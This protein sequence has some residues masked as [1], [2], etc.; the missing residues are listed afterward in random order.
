MSLASVKSQIQ[1]LRVRCRHFG[2]LLPLP[3]LLLASS[4]VAKDISTDLN[5]VPISSD[6]EA[7]DSPWG[8]ASGGEWLS[9][10]PQFNPMLGRAGVKWLRA[11]QEWKTIQPTHGYW[12][13]AAAD[14]LVQ[15]ARANDLRLSWVLAYLAPWAS[16]DGGTRKFPIKD[17]QY[18]RDYVVQLVGR[19]HRDIKYWEVWNEFN[20]SF[21][22]SGTPKIYAELVREA[23]ISAKA[24]DPSAK[25][26][27][28]V[29]N[30]DVHFLDAVIK[31]GAAGHFDYVCVHPYEKLGALENDGEIDFLAMTAALRQMLA[32]NN[33][34]VDMPLW[35]TEMGEQTSV[36]P[37]QQADGKQAVMLAKAYLLSLAAGF[38]KIFWFEARGPSYG[39]NT[40]H[41]IIRSD[42]SVRPSYRALKTLSTILGAAPVG[43][44]W[45][46]MG[47]G[48]FGFLFQ[49][50][51]RATLAAWAPSKG[52]IRLTFPGDVRVVDLEGNQTFIRSGEELVLTK[53][54]ILMIDP[55]DQILRA[56]ERN[57]NQPYPW[58][59]NYA[60][61]QTVK[62]KLGSTNVEDGIKQIKVD[63]TDAVNGGNDSWRRMNF[64]RA[65]KEGHYAYF[66]TD[67]GFARAGMNEM[68]IKVVVRRLEPNKVA[69]F[70]LTYE[71][72]SGYV[73]TGYANVPEGDEWH[74]LVWKINDA[75][76]V[77]QWGWNFR[78]NAISSPNEFLIKEVSI[79]RGSG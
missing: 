68:E 57:K 11:F 44:G 72:K 66:T 7:Q 78:L 56:A 47:S 35:I 69:G 39:N 17:I 76:F 58:G 23:S 40:D 59:G 43:K 75:N 77:G 29:A 28:S 71:S 63:T 74:E 53:T 15:N 79:K 5:G 70:S 55:P 25:I 65:D 33:Q 2:F 36:T 49:G 3:F 26:G 67:P 34:P 12:N 41:G 61:A 52:N 60:Q 21:A 16:A 4:V 6:V 19:Y 24:V 46:E 27:L 1:S 20:G 73:G 22:D 37:D 62:V 30:F 42:F 64:S 31:A 50:S 32:A 18:W 54:P 10:Y 45:V 51:G 13:W 14:H 8:I 9:A 48:G 38:Q